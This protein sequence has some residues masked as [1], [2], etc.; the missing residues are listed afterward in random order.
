[1]RNLTGYLKKTLLAI[2]LSL[3]ISPLFVH[4]VLAQDSPFN[5]TSY[6]VHKVNG[7]NVNTELTLHVTTEARRVLSIYTVSIQAPNIKASCFDSSG[8]SIN[9]QSYNRTSTTEH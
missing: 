9:C 3:T 7:S 5:V 8:S 6:F 2:S 4:N 1:M